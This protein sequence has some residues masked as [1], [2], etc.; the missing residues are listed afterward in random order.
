M[1]FFTVSNVR[2]GLRRKTSV[3]YQDI[4]HIISWVTGYRKYELQFSRPLSIV[5][6]L[7]ILYYISKLKQQVPLA[8][9]MQKQP[10]YKYDFYVNRHVLIPRPETEQMV[11]DIIAG[12]ILKDHTSVLDIG[13]GCGN[14][15][16]VL[17][18]EYP[19]LAVTAV[20]SSAAALRVARYN[21][22]NIIGRQH[23]ICFRKKDFYK[24]KYQENSL[25]DTVITNPPY[26]GFR[27]K[28]DVAPA[29]KKYE[30]YRAL[31]AGEN[32]MAMITAVLQKLWLI[33]QHNGLLI[34]E[35]GY[36]QKAA[37]TGLACKKFRHIEFKRDFNN[38]D[39]FFYGYGFKG[40]SNK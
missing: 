7:K 16:V 11:A 18:S 39:R 35:I 2:A 30:P 9:I 10:F 17:K 5:S 13:C 37:V 27:E 22:F 20:D 15:A 29:V 31:F 1:S 33:L 36:K 40:C 12:G 32:G 6:Y 38:F 19:G 26:I 28:R 34:M 14:I 3:N 21:A 8:Y 4:D 23:G 24:V 25:F